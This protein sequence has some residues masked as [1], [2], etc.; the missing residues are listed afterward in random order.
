MF[1]YVIFTYYTFVNLV[2]PHC[3]DS[4]LGCYMQ[5]KFGAT[6]NS[7]YCLHSMQVIITEEE[8]RGF[9]KLGDLNVDLRSDI[10]VVGKHFREVIL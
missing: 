2:I 5:S 4:I 7:I 6:S 8:E 10:P 1:Q 3:T 9:K